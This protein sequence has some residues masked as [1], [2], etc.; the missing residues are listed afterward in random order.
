MEA[1]IWARMITLQ[2]HISSRT[3]QSL[4]CTCMSAWYFLAYPNQL[5]CGLRLEGATSLGH[6]RLATSATSVVLTQ[7]SSAAPKLF[8]L[9]GKQHQ[10]KVGGDIQRWRGLKSSNTSGKRCYEC[11]LKHT[12]KQPQMHMHNL[13]INWM[14]HQ[15]A[16]GV[17]FKTDTLGGK[18]I[19]SGDSSNT[20]G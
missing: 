3:A 9:L 5:W 13:R 6:L 8:L 20:A 17:C 2:P 18:Q 1:S 11:A 16:S 7:A 12:I 15:V 19:W 14:A 10:L 4:P